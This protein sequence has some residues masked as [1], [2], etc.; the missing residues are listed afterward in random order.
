MKRFKDS[1]AF[2]ILNSFWI[3]FCCTE[4]GK[5]YACG[6]SYSLGVDVVLEFYN[7]Q[8][9]DTISAVEIIMPL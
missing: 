3:Y 2:K 1:E 7:I 4:H 6:T 8:E 5:V 9:A